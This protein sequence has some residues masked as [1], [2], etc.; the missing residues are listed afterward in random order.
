MR[1]EG[2]AMQGRVS[3]KY[4]VAYLSVQASDMAHATATVLLT[5]R[6][7]IAGD[8]SLLASYETD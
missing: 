1:G 5:E 4:G 8:F 2:S 7:F 6:R 3:R